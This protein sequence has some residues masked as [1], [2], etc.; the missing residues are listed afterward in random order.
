[1]E[2][3]ESQFPE[4]P[5]FS[6]EGAS[7]PAEWLVNI[8]TQARTPAQHS[9]YSKLLAT[10][11]ISTLAAARL[12]P[13][14]CMHIEVIA[15]VVQSDLSNPRYLSQT[16]SAHVPSSNRDPKGGP[17]LL[18]QIPC[19]VSHLQILGCAWQADQAGHADRFA[20]AYQASQLRQDNENALTEGIPALGRGA[21][22]SVATLRE[23]QVRHDTVTPF[24]HQYLVL[25]KVGSVCLQF[26]W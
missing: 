6:E 1:M 23:L 9:D 25:I 15:K 11:H 7:N 12:K 22:T 24:W 4:V 2:Y 14:T 5:R 8:T 18:M 26:A 3:F 17:S 10:A 21:R 13:C 20:A 16:V 19:A